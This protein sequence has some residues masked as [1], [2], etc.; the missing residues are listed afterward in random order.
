MAKYKL[1]DLFCG[2]GG[3]SAGFIKPH[4]CGR[5]ESVL[6]I[7]ND[8]AAVATY[9]E[10]FGEHC[11]DE[12]IEMW[13]QKNSV[14]QADVVIGGP[15]CQGFSL[16]NKSR[17]GDIR[18]AL[19]EP[20]MDIVSLSGASVFV[21]ENV[22]GLLKSSEFN[23]I[24]KRALSIG[25]RLLS[26]EVLNTADYGV[27]QTRKRTI[28]VGVRESSF[29][30]CHLMDFPPPPSHQPPGD[31]GNLPVWRSVREFIS[32]LSPPKGT[33]IRG[34]APPYDL[35]FGRN[36]TEVSKE[37]YKA[38]P[39][40]GNRF[41][42]QKNRPD[43]TPACWIK[44]KSGGTD[45]FGRLWWDRPSVTIRTEFF[46][47]EKGRYLHPE[48][49]RPIT[50]REAARLMSFPDDFVFKGTKIE[51]AKQIGNAVPPVFAGK[52]ADFVCELLGKRLSH[53]QKV[54]KKESGA[55]A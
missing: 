5:F 51:V 24:A 38:V 7:D 19:W 50:H 55:V 37:R 26:P 43:L 14:P 15:P 48:A 22:P 41:D 27:P 30:L 28:I 20:Y 40:G 11:F 45:L 34:V 46:K 16:L 23:A 31:N 49:D 35:H 18:R 54:E 10:N 3:L 25:F 1:I 12:N 4:F 42:L 33:E 21:M 2:A 6:A 32:D 52:I 44:K 47:P 39:I 36:P 53:G 8:R 17:E 9:N 13:L 29:D